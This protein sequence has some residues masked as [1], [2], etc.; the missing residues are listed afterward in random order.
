[1]DSGVF[2][3]FPSTNLVFDGSVPKRKATDPVSP[4]LEYGKQKAVTERQLLRMGGPVSVI[5]FTKVIPKQYSLFEDWRQALLAEES[6]HPY[7]DLMVSPVPLDLALNVF[8]QIR[9]ERLSGITHVSGTR[10]VSYADIALHIAK[11][12]SADEE[13]IQAR[14]HSK[15]LSNGRFKVLRHGRTSLWLAG[16]GF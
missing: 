13:L 3:V 7:S 6:I 4:R 10:D 8:T 1:M 15:S 9:N 2:V 16:F 14:P 11:H 5:R 12:L